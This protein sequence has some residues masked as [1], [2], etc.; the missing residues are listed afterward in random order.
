M[1]GPALT[2]Q[3]RVCR[4]DEVLASDI[5]DETVMMDMNKGRYYGLNATGTRLWTLLAKPI[6]IRDLCA[7][8][9]AELPVSPAQCER[10]VIDFIGALVARGLVQV[11]SEDA[12]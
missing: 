11:V 6:V 10:D 9:T 5:G 7:Y 1:S 12:S 2:S 8:L 3:T 4:I